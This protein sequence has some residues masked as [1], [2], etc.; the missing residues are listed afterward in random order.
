[1]HAGGWKPYQVMLPHHTGGQ[2]FIRRRLESV[3]RDRDSRV[4]DMMLPQDTRL[5]STGH[6]Q[7][8]VKLGSP[9]PSKLIPWPQ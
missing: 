1:L 6:E 9:L 5:S 3:A 7:S 2:I 4:G 8:G